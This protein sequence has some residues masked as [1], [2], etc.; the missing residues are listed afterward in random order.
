MEKNFLKQNVDGSPYIDAIYDAGSLA[1]KDNQAINSTIGSL[2]D[3]NGS[4]IAFDSVYKCM[5]CLDKK[6]KAPYASNLTGNADFV[7]AAF[8]WLNRSSHINLYHKQ[9]ATIGGTG[10]LYLAF[11]SLAEVNSSI[12]LPD[13]A[14]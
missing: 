8:D 3:E 12:L 7:Q 11:N 9:I 5:D 13:I 6:A 2:Y 14:W 4:I 1:K 10:A